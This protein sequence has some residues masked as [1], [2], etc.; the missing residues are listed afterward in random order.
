MK[1]E[2]PEPLTEYQMHVKWELALAEAVASGWTSITYTDFKDFLKLINDDDI[3]IQFPG[4]QVRGIFVNKSPAERQKGI[5][6]IAR[7]NG[8]P[9]T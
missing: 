7:K 9:V 8:L 6:T 4:N 5:N 3:R 1:P 2:Q